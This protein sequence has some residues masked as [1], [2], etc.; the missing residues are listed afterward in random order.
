MLVST[1]SEV[2]LLTL[3]SHSQELE[4]LLEDIRKDMSKLQGSQCA[5]FS[6]VHAVSSAWHAGAVHSPFLRHQQLSDQMSPPP[7]NFPPISPIRC[8]SY[9]FM[10]QIPIIQAYGCAVPVSWWAD[11]LFYL[12]TAHTEQCK[13]HRARENAKKSSARKLRCHIP[14]PTHLPQVLSSAFQPLTATIW[15]KDDKNTMLCFILNNSFG[16][17][18][19]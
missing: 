10:Q 16:Q 6:F 19:F 9:N 13:E 1:H 15:K 14:G 2:T 18:L 7:W 17:S 3:Q 4:E 12:K 5:P 8:P 11:H